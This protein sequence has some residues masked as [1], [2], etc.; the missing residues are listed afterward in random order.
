MANKTYNP[1][2]IENGDI[3][4][5]KTKVKYFPAW[6]DTSTD[7]DNI[8]TSTITAFYTSSAQVTGSIEGYYY[9]NVYQENPA[10]I[11]DTEPQ[12]SIAYGHT[13]SYTDSNSQPIG[14][15]S[16]NIV[17]NTLGLS[18]QYNNL[19]Q[20]WAIYRQMVNVVLPS[21]NASTNNLSYIQ[22]NG[23]N[24]TMSNIYVVALSR[25]RIKDYINPTWQLALSKSINIIPSTTAIVNNEYNTIVS[26]TTNVCGKFYADRGLIILDADVLYA[27]GALSQ[28]ALVAGKQTPVTTINGR[29]TAYYTAS[30]VL[31]NFYNSIA[32]GSNFYAQSVENVQSTHYFVRARNNEFNWSVNPT[33]NPDSGGNIGA[34]SEKRTFITSV[35]LYD[36]NYTDGTYAGDLLAV[37]K[38]SKPIPKDGTSEALIKVRLDF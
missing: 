5:G 8:Q 31:K 10:V 3:V 20:P 6:S 11:F 35:G 13:S 27:S 29:S 38:L 7:V 24:V 34:D 26:G 25:S 2:S 1:L 19:Y 4:V 30:L 9:W 14:V 28:S 33:W 22:A 15:F 36:G 12:F 21:G 17:G 23:T 16:A 37:A 18:D 32:T